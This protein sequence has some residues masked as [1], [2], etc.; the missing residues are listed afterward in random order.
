MRRRSLSSQEPELVYQ[1]KGAAVLNRPEG[2]ST[3]NI[4]KPRFQVV[5][6]FTQES[7]DDVA[8]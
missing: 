5:D 8:T 4:L 3:L 1:V 7:L 6:H 2:T